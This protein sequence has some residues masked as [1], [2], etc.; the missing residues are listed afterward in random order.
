VPAIARRRAKDIV[1]NDG[2]RR[3][4]TRVRSTIMG[5]GGLRDTR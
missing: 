2:T 1:G 4:M 5:F 3:C